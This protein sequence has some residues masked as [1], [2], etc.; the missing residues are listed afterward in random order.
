MRNGLDLRFSPFLKDTWPNFLLLGRNPYSDDNIFVCIHNDALLIPRE[1]LCRYVECVEGVMQK[2][3]ETML[4]QEARCREEGEGERGL[5]RD[6]R[7]RLHSD[8]PVDAFRMLGAQIELVGA[9]RC[10][11]LI[12]SVCLVGASVLLRASDSMLSLS[13]GSLLE[14]SQGLLD[15]GVDYLCVGINDSADACKLSDDIESRVSE[16]LEDSNDDGKQMS[17]AHLSLSALH[18]A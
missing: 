16:L 18:D 1:S 14:N 6:K 12:S 10:G 9:S 7:G 13:R 3:I 2:Q 4:S 11:I 15:C 17:R 5:V 8:V